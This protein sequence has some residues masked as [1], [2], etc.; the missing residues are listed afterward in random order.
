MIAPATTGVEAVRPGFYGWRILGVG[1]LAQL[2]ANAITLSAFS[3]FVLPLSESFSVS[4]G[5]ITLGMTIA[6]GCLGL[7]GPLVGR[8]T[9]RGHAR[10]LMTGGALMSGC[11]LLVLS[12]VEDL[13][14]FALVYGGLVCIGAAMFGIMPSMTLVANWFVKRRGF[15][16][17][18]TF[19]GATIA[20]AVA[21]VTAQYLIDVS[22]WRTALFAFGLVA[23]AVGV[24]S[25]AFLVVGR[26]E[27]VGQLPDG[28]PTTPSSTSPSAPASASAPA[29]FS[30]SASPSAPASALMSAPSTRVRDVQELV[31]D[32]RLWLIALG[33]GLVLTSPVVLLTLLVP[34]GMSLGYS[35]QQANLFLVAMM[36][37]SLLGKLGLGELADRVAPKPIIVL[38]VLANIAVWLIFLSEPSFVLFVVTGAVFGIGIG[39]AAPVQGVI[40]GRCFGRVNFGTASGLGGIVSILLLILATLMSAALQGEN[41]EGYPLIFRLQAGLILLGGLVLAMVRV[42]T[43][44]PVDD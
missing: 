23:L 13:A 37:F 11:G 9:D 29:S 19:A 18:V 26:P 12:Q 21:P 4:T 28:E 35:A 17:G 44:E 20:S 10:W 24:P 8:W 6:I 38:I 31:R 25:F 36:P 14:L 43:S 39:G 30:A 27:E 32:P 15:A 5:T 41:G 2:L 16:L 42:P 33:F 3:N 34:Y 7:F 22:G 1:F 40:V